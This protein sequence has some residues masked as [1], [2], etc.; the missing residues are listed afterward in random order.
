M[1]NKFV[2]SINLS[3]NYLLV[4]CFSLIIVET[5][6][7]IKYFI[8]LKLYSRQL[9]QNEQKTFDGKKGID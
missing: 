2:I 1:K 9:P 5:T 3:C 4:L 6:T 7:K 8:L